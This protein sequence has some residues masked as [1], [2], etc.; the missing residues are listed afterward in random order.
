LLLPQPHKKSQQVEPPPRLDTP[1]ECKRSEERSR[2][3]WLELQV[4]REEVAREGD[5]LAVDRDRYEL[6]R[7]T[8]VFAFQ[9]VLAVIMLLAAVIVIVLEPG[10]ASS[11]LLGGGGIGGAAAVLKRRA[12]E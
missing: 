8:I 11:A 5:R 9:I 10:L 4:E 7:D 12:K 6:T 1:E 3:R 2:A